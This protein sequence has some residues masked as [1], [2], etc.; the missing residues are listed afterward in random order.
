MT[1]ADHEILVVDDD[2]DIREATAFVL[3][4]AGYRVS[5]A[6]NGA[7]ALDRLH[8]GT[9]PSLILLDLMMPIMDGWQFLAEVAREPRLA[10]IPIV[11]ITGAGAPVLRTMSPG[12]SAILE[13]PVNLDL[14]LATVQRYCQASPPS[15]DSRRAGRGEDDG[16]R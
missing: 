1:S 12:V 14:L 5:T 8:G 10:A 16:E 6:E 9:A 7:R 15:G 3:E 11:A 2:I 4:D 13:K